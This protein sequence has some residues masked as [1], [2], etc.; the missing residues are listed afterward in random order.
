[1]VR[2]FTLE[3]SY[4]DVDNPWKGVLSATVFAVWL[5]YHIMLKKTSG[6]LV[7]GRDMIFNLSH[8]AN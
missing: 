2:A 7:F 8:V 5:T 4:L 6:Q 3:E 1:M